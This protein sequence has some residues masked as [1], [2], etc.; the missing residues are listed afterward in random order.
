[1]RGFAG[2]HL[3]VRQIVCRVE[4]G[5]GHHDGEMAEARNLR[6]HREEGVDHARAEA[7]GDDDAVD[8]SDVEMLRRGFDRERADDAGALA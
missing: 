5:A 4:I 1:V 6:Q 7:F 3:E 8:V 2:D